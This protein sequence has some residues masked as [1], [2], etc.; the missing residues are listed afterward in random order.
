MKD[1]SSPRREKKLFNFE[2]FKEAWVNACVHNKW[3]DGLPPAVYWFAALTAAFL[4]K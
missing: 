3:T 2:A 4:K 1:I